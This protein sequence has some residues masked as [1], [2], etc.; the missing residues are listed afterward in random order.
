MSGDAVV[1]V[2]C[3][4]CGKTRD[5]RPGE[6]PAG[7]FPMCDRCYGP[8]MPRRAEGRLP[9]PTSTQQDHR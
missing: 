4:T 9:T 6:I 3:S 2:K 5:V 7:G 8:M 1:V